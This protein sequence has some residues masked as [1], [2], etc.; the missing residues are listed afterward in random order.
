MF[1][2]FSLQPQAFGLD[3]SDLS[4]KIC[5]L[6]KKKNELELASFGTSPIPPGIIERG[7]IKNQEKLIEILKKALKDLKGR[8][9]DTKYVIASLPEEKAFLQVI[10]LP[11]MK[12]EELTQAIRFEAEN[13]IPYSIDTV[14]LDFQIVPP[15]HDHLDHLDVLLASLPKATVDSYVSVL[16][17]AGLIPQALEIESLAV[18]RALIEKELAPVPVLV[19]DFGATRTSFI[20]FS[21]YSLRFTASIT[22]SSQQL[23]KSIAKSLTVDEKVAE[24][25]KKRYG[26]GAT[27]N[28][29]GRQVFEALIPP[30]V[31][32][33]EQ[34]RKHID[35]YDSHPFHQHLGQKEGRIRKILLCGG[36][37]NLP[38]LS[39]FLTKELKIETSLGNPWVN[40]FPA[41]F[42]KVPPLPFHESLRFA[43]ALGLALR[44][45]SQKT[46]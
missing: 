29:E 32:L 22:V 33:V 2:I 3:I 40:I 5:R 43:T 34:I 30:L 35:Y 13:Y 10:Q 44:G 14:Y 24:E 17:K 15:V 25:L 36:G 39:E 21:G 6:R 42:K 11:R 46:E 38:G 45:I 9:I 18:S 16:Q 4:L 23:T 31:D 7:E 19:V 12:P 41:P 27:E 20:V 37:A 8:Q 26:V 1:E 28:S